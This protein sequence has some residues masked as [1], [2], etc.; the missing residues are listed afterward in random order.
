M[1]NGI[2]TYIIIGEREGSSQ[3]TRTSGMSSFIT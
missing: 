1:L 2:K 3:T